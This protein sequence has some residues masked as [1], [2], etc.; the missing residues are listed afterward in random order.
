MVLKQ[1]GANVNVSG[2]N[3]GIS[4]VVAE[5]DPADIVVIV[6]PTVFGKSEHFS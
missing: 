4:A 5:T 1:L 6:L 3:T 2:V